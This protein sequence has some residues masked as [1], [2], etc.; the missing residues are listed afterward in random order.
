MRPLNRGQLQSHGADQ[1]VEEQGGSQR[2]NAELAHATGVH[3]SQEHTANHDA[4][5]S[6]S[7]RGVPRGRQVFL[8]PGG[9]YLYYFYEF[10]WAL[11]LQSLPPMPQRLIHNTGYWE[12]RGASL[13]KGCS[14]LISLVGRLLVSNQMG[15]S[16]AQAMQTPSWEPDSGNH[17]VVI[18]FGQE[19]EEAGVRGTVGGQG[20]KIETRSLS[21]D[22]P[23]FRTQLHRQI[24]NTT[25]IKLVTDGA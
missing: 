7:L 16:M 17:H 24:G 12:R 1:Q 18:A 6:R 25:P 3:Q 8:I 4:I 22:Q 13:W 15:R 10:C 11:K 5:L 14:S 21:P 23:Q 9:L 19:G 20:S 2:L